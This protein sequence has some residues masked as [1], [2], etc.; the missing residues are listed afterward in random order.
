AYRA[1][2]QEGHRPQAQEGQEV[3]QRFALTGKRAF[4]T[5]GSRG[6]GRAIAKG[7]AR[8]GADVAFSYHERRAE[9]VK[10][11]P[12]VH[13][14]GRRGGARDLDVSDRASVESAAKDAQAAL[15]SL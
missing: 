5:G 11:L 7:L 13:A 3:M 4:V 14:L 2:R 10:I 12:D 6:I 15:G 8:A 9:A 1:R